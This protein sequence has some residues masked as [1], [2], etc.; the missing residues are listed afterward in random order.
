MLSKVTGPTTVLTLSGS[1]QTVIPT[2]YDG[3]APK[4][5]RIAVAAAAFIA[6]NTTATAGAGILLPAGTAEHFKLENSMTLTSTG[7]S[8]TVPSNIA[9]YTVNTATISVLQAAS[10]GLISI[11]PVA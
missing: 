7:T 6:F 8:A 1:A 10:G 9:T 2:N 5:V 11:T 3:K 4:V